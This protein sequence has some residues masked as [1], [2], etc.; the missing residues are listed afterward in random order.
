MTA[1][2]KKRVGGLVYAEVPVLSP[3]GRLYF[4]KMVTPNCLSHPTYS[5]YN[6][7]D[8]PFTKKWG[9]YSPPALSSLCVA[10]SV[11]LSQ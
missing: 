1:K 6:V 10:T 7:A 3:L 8:M 5:S 11:C 9:L 2:K 4:P